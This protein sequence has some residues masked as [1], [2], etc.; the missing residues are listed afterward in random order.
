MMLGVKG[1]SASIAAL[2]AIVAVAAPHPV[3]PTATAAIVGD[4]TPASDWGTARQDYATQVV[5]LVNKHRASLGLAPLKVS[6]TLTNSAVWKARHMAEYRYMTHNDPAPPVARTA[7]DRIQTCGYNSGWGE[8]IAYGYSTPQ[9]VMN[10]WLNSPDH[11]ANIEKA[12]FK[13]IGVGAAA[14]DSGTLYWAQNFGTYDDSGSVTPPPPPPPPATTTV[15]AF[16]SA[17]TIQT[18]SLRAGDATRLNADDGSYYEVN[19][20]YSYRRTSWYGTFKAVPNSLRALKGTYRGK[21]SVSCSQTVAIWKWTTSSWV[22]LDSRSVST[23]E[24]EINVTPSGTLADYVSGSSGDGDVA[25]QVRCS[26]SDYT[27]FY[28]SGDLM[29]IVYEKS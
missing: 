24:V 10:A 29:K 3:A 9:A 16:P 17:T 18:G 14:A 26:R 23:T 4:C 21:N 7:A 11:R 22:V 27:S 20:N 19:R 28:S 5:D 25:I 15:T 1:F 12:T 13:V 6:P 2:V 8:N